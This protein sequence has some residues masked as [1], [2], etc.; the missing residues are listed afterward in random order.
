MIN[1]HDDPKPNDK[2]MLFD[3]NSSVVF[4]LIN[5]NVWICNNWQHG[6]WSKDSVIICSISGK[7]NFLHLVVKK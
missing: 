3:V 2:L 4:F 1:L 6:Q 7:T 5:E